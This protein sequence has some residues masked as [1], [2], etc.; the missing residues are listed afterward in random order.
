MQHKLDPPK[1]T[2]IYLKKKNCFKECSV[3]IA[4]YTKREK[5]AHFPDKE[6]T[7]LENP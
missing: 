6:M 2:F 4:V 5:N 1:I 7:K 3:N